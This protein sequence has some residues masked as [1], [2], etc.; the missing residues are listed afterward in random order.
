MGARWVRNQDRLD[1]W[2]RPI[3]RRA[4]EVLGDL[5]GRR[6][7]D[8]GCGC[9]ASSLEL[10][11]AVGANGFVT[12]VDVSSAM[13]ERAQQRSRG[14]P[15][16]EFVEADAATFRSDQRWDAMHSRFGVMFF[17]D[18]D[19]AFRNLRDLL[20]PGASLS[21]VCWQGLEANEWANL[22][23]AA[24]DRVLGPAEPREPGPGPFRFASR[25]EVTDI[26]SSA[27]FR[28]IAFESE[29]AER[30]A[31]TLGEAVELFGRQ[32]GPVAR[33]LQEVP[34]ESREAALD[35]LATALEPRVDASD[36]QVRLQTATWFVFAKA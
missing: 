7:L 30:P 8:V 12:G 26:L 14:I 36:S 10:A 15:Q 24:V 35:S 23:I 34:D 20:A 33:R 25:D 22:P 3:G 9:G 11:A 29:V 5:R 2:L 19:A 17:D 18:N 31:G 21:F 27:G 6:V 28:E 16:L 32:V 4:I 13:L 1:E